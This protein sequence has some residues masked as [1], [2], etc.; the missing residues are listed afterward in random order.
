M[1]KLDH[2]ITRL[3]LSKGK[4]AFI[5][6]GLLSTIWF[7]I[8]VIPKPS[9]ATYPCMRAAAPVMST[10]VIWL[11][12]TGAFVFLSR[13]MASLIEKKRFMSALVFVIPLI[14]L[15]FF[16]ASENTL[17]SFGAEIIATDPIHI[18]TQPFG[19]AKGIFPGRVV[20]F[21]DP[22]AT[23]ENSANKTNW[24]GII[25]ENDDVYY[26]AKNNDPVVIQQMMDSSLIYLTGAKTI[27]TAW[28]SVFKYYNRSV[29]GEDRGYAAG[30]KIFIK[31][32]NQGFGFK[33]NMNPN[34]TQRDESAHGNFHPHGLGTSPYSVISTIKQLVHEAGVAEEDIYVGD[35]HQNFN[36]VYYNLL[37]GAFQNIH[38]MGMNSGEVTNCE[39][40]GRTL[41]VPSD[42]DVVF[43]S[44]P[45]DLS[46]KLYQQII[47]AKYM[48]NISGLKAHR[49]AGITFFA[50]NHFGS[51][52]RI[53]AMHLHPS[54][55][56]NVQGYKKY[57]VLTDLMGHKDLGG[58]TVLF[59][60][61]GLWGC[62]PCELERPRKW[63]MAPFSGEWTSSI[64]MSLD[65]VAI[66]S[67]GFDF[68]RAEY[69]NAIWGN[70]AYPNKWE[71]V[72]DYL[73]QAASDDFWP[74]GLIYDPENDG[75]KLGSLGVHEHWNN[76]T[77]MEYSKNVD[78]MQGGIELLK[79]HSFITLAVSSNDFSKRNGQ[80]EGS[81]SLYPNPASEQVS[82]SINDNYFGSVVIEI[83]DLGGRK[84][85]SMSFVKSSDNHQ[86][87]LSIRDIK[88][89][90]YTV[91]V[92]LGNQH[93]S[94]NLLIQ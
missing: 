56:G 30:E 5:A 78:P 39:S 65:P 48:I 72:D 17:P 44:D 33:E 79:L 54:L 37:R 59:I 2:L 7:L 51:H 76:A 23:N 31:T 24:T 85:R 21:Y 35:P 73:H 19:E 88:S 32:N 49:G 63:T 42:N 81:F 69:T 84:L 46:D 67:V 3:K 25:D 66:A 28:D 15:G 4:I 8:R 26:Q 16:A 10:F 40:Y 9:R 36:N 50:K 53:N 12:S 45:S 60:I 70:E 86:E 62:S 71:G 41:S 18:S 64:F 87:I 47:D 38:I 22:D 11:I 14:I 34:L 80:P 43:Y 92:K 68:L 1:K 27:K 29:L 89:G 61:D 91:S 93:F 90:I 83:Y 55:P 13:R 52:P 77:D 57:R 20:W 82:I 6:L 94:K 58:K 74:E 75:I